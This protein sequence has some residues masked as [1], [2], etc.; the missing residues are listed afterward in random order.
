MSRKLPLLGNYQDRNAMGT[1][2]ETLVHD[3][4]PVR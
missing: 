3:S 4:L 2:K 1:V